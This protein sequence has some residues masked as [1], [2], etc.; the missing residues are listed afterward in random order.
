MT[1]VKEL[2]AGPPAGVVDKQMKAS[3][4]L[5]AGSLSF[6]ASGFCLRFSTW[7]FLEVCSAQGIV[8]L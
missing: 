6:I 8:L 2:K 1:G 7:Y 4:H 3:I 5:L